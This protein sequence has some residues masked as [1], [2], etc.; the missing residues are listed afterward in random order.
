MYCGMATTGPLVS[1]LARIVWA[2]PA[3]R[4]VTNLST[5]KAPE[6]VPAP[7]TIAPAVTALLI[8]PATVRQALATLRQSLLLLPLVVTYTSYGTGRDDKLQASIA[9]ASAR[10]IPSV[11][12]ETFL[13]II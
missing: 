9:Q 4:K 6:N 13:K 11:L 7:I 5:T 1:E 3:P 12:S 8:A 2:W 10:V